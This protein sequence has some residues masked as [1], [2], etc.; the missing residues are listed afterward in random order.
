MKLYIKRSVSPDKS[1]F[2]VFAELGNEKYNVTF[3]GKKPVSKIVISDCNNNTV[4]TIRRIPIVGAQ[5]YVFKAGKSHLTFVALISQSSIVGHYY[6]NNWHISGDIATGCY[7][8]ID[9]DKS[10]I[11]TQKKLADYSELTINNDKDE[12]YCVATSVCINLINTVDKLA[13]QAV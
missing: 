1:C 4:L 6:G 7:S 3:A 5:T 9:V 8:I 13:V 10:V 11:S 12:L 2:N